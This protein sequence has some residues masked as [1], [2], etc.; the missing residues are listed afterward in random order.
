M[1]YSAFKIVYKNSSL[2]KICFEISQVLFKNFVKLKVKF[3]HNL[4]KIFSTFL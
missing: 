3:T 2:F 4:L 1:L